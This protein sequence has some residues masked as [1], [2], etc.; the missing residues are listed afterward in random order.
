VAKAAKESDRQST[1]RLVA[2]LGSENY[3]IERIRDEMDKRDWSQAELSRRMEK[4]ARE[5]NGGVLAQGVLSKMLRG[6]QDGRGRHVSIDQLITLS[7]VFGIPLNEL[8][9][10]ASTLANIRGW[11]YYFESLDIANDIRHLITRKMERLAD[12]RKLIET[13]PELSEQIVD[14]ARDVYRLRRSDFIE[15]IRNDALHVEG[16][17]PD[18]YLDPQLMSYGLHR[19][20]AVAVATELLDP[21]A[22]TSDEALYRSA[23]ALLLDDVPE[24]GERDE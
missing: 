24:E 8:L 22:S 16:S 7:K 4:S 20:P 10:P 2:E 1:Y 15:V 3:V 9:V 18:E 17:M 6:G 23:K 12:I 13:S 21:S 11:R 14:H 5:G 19:F